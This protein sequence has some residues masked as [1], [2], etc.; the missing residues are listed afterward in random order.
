MYLNFNFFGSNAYGIKSAARRYFD[1]P[2]EELKIQEE[3][4]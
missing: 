4:C 1:K 3:P 2:V